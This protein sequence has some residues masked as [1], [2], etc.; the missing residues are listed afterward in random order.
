MAVITAT[1]NEV[2]FTRIAEGLGAVIQKFETQ[3]NDTIDAI[4]T[5]EEATTADLLTAQI[6]VA[7]FQTAIQ[8]TTGITSALSSAF[9]NITQKIQ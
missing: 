7:E 3:L 6:A 8:L 4:S 1:G 9:Q 5:A 2:T